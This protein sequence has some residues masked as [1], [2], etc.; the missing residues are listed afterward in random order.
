MPSPSSVCICLY[1]CSQKSEE[2]VGFPVAIVICS[3][4]RLQSSPRVAVFLL[5]SHLPIRLCLPIIQCPAVE[6]VLN[7]ERIMGIMVSLHK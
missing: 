3:Y 4:D 6:A 1:I 2:D 5:Q 7:L